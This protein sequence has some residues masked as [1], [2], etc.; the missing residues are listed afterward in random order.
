MTITLL[1]WMRSRCNL[2]YLLFDILPA[3]FFDRGSMQTQLV[4]LV[5]TW[6][7]K[8]CY[9]K[10]T[11]TRWE[12]HVCSNGQKVATSTRN[13]S[14][15]LLCAGRHVEYRRDPIWALEWLPAIPWQKQCTGGCPLSLSETTLTWNS[16]FNNS[17]DG[18]LCFRLSSAASVH[19]QKHISPVLR[20]TGSPPCIPIVLIYAPDYYALIQVCHLLT[21]YPF[22]PATWYLGDSS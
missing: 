21:L 19:Q 9:F 4:V 17:A 11:M 5:C 1:T 8:W 15:P 16:E 14:E 20:T 3:E 6:L 22:H 7:Q 2:Y 10:S 18:H 13:L 12:W